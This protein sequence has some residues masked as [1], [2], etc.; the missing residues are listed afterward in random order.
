VV[1]L[2][3]T[4]GSENGDEDERRTCNS[5][6]LLPLRHNIRHQVRLL[7]HRSLLIIKH[8]RLFTGKVRHGKEENVHSESLS[9][10]SSRAWKLQSP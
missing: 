2:D 7:P 4:T 5:S 1:L 8:G 6:M 3:A 10:F 9:S